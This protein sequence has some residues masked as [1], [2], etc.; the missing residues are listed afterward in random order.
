M[1]WYV[2]YYDSG[3]VDVTDYVKEISKF[4]YDIDNRI[5][6]VGSIIN[7]LF[8]GTAPIDEGKYKIVLGDSPN[9]H[10]YLFG[11]PYDGIEVLEDDDLISVTMVDYL[12]YKLDKKVPLKVTGEGD[13]PRL[14][15]G[16]FDVNSI[17]DFK[18]PYRTRQHDVDFEGFTTV[19]EENY[20]DGI[21]NTIEVTE[22]FRYETKGVISAQNQTKNIGTTY[23]K[24]ND[25]INDIVTGAGMT[26]QVDYEY[27]D[28]SIVDASSNLMYSAKKIWDVKCVNGFIIV[29]CS[30]E[31]YLR[32]RSYNADGSGYNGQLDWVSRD[33][34][35]DE[36]GEDNIGYQI[37]PDYKNK[38]VYIPMWRCASFNAGVGDNTYLLRMVKI[39]VSDAGVLSVDYTDDYSAG[40]LFDVDSPAD[41]RIALRERNARFLRVAVGFILMHFYIDGSVTNFVIVELLPS[42]QNKIWVIDPD[43]RISGDWQVNY[44]SRDTFYYFVPDS[45]SGAVISINWD[46]ANYVKEFFRID[47]PELTS[48]YKVQGYAGTIV[49]EDDPPN[50]SGL[51]PVAIW[52]ESILYEK[53]STY[54]HHWYH[55]PQLPNGVMYKKAIRSKYTWEMSDYAG[56]G[57]TWAAQL[58]AGTAWDNVDD[59]L[60]YWKTNA[61][62]DPATLYWK[63]R[64]N[65]VYRRLYLYQHGAYID[66]KQQFIDA[67]VTFGYFYSQIDGKVRLFRIRGTGASLGTLSDVLY[68]KKFKGFSRFADEFTIKVLGRR[69]TFGSGDREK[70]IKTIMGDYGWVSPSQVK[71]YTD[72]V[73]YI[74]GL[75]EGI[76]LDMDLGA[77]FTVASTYLPDLGKTFIYDSITY[78]LIGAEV[79]VDEWAIRLIGIKEAA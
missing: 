60:L 66:R 56:V 25:I 36:N 30:T 37:Y 64:S 70:E 75:Q 49:S 23:V 48:G 42:A 35:E 33:W 47:M 74:N 50:N 62:E 17:N 46:G 12:L 63:I 6:G 1:P 68:T 71:F 15:G 3:W 45:L 43:K 77:F 24:I 76:E 79:D 34:I 16:E 4:K 41:Q 39:N 78:I 67:Y 51:Y 44:T 10:Y 14:G 21:G 13:A 53:W 2:Y 72:W 19:D 32:L 65:Y 27:G 58:Y 52:R 29:L 22:P 59:K 8:E 20:S 7:I 38:K 11:V 40:N 28:E 61:D 9:D 69:L 26:L 73:T 5:Q 54:N 55:I 18:V 31:G 57:D